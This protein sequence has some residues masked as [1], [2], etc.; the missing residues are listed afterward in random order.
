V[1]A[2][3]PIYNGDE[4]HETDFAIDMVATLRT[5]ARAADDLAVRYRELARRLAAQVDG[6]VPSDVDPS[7]PP[8]GQAF[9]EVYQQGHAILRMLYERRATSDPSLDKQ[10]SAGIELEVSP[11]SCKYCPG[12]LLWTR[13]EAGKF[14]PLD[15]QPFPALAIPPSER[16]LP[17]LNVSRD[18]QPPRM[19]RARDR[20][21]GYVYRRHTC[22]DP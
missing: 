14:L 20:T 13:D 21:E 2:A 4:D 12:L 18:N 19:R 5:A 1:S 6:D 10:A 16:W 22:P 7:G 11:S 3:D 8:I 15:P 17:D 9:R